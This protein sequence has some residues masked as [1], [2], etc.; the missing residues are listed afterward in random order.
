MAA[1]TRGD[2]LLTDQQLCEL[3]NVTPRTSLRWRRDGRG[4]RFIR[5]GVRRVAYR[6]RDVDTWLSART[7]DHRAAEAAARR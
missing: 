6:R 4:P 7:F 3:L 1:S 5:V 2:E